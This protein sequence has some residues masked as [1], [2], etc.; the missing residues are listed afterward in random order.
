MEMPQNIVEVEED[1]IPDDAVVDERPEASKRVIVTRKGRR[2]QLPTW[3]NDY[4]TD[5]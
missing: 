3:L 5:E 4:E 1:P 2:V